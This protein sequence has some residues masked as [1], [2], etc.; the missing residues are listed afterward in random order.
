MKEE[1]DNEEK[2]SG[3]DEEQ[4]I[5]LLELALK[6]WDARKKILL[7]GLYGAILGIIIA[8]STPKEYTATTR[9]V[10]ETGAARSNNL[11]AIA[12]LAGIGG[13]STGGADAVYPSLYP[14][15]VASKPFTF[16]L[17]D[18]M[19]PV[20]KS[21]VDSLTLYEIIAQ[22]TSKPWWNVITGLP[23]RIVGTVTGA[24]EPK[25][26][27]R[28]INQG[29]SESSDS[30]NM[31]A[32][33]VDVF[34]LT[35]SQLGVMGQINQRVSANLD[36]RNNVVTISVTLQDPLAAATLADTV[37]ARLK[38]YVVAYRTDK[39]RNDLEYAKKLKEEAKETYYEAQQKYANY[40]D[41]NQGLV[42]RSA[43]I[44]QERLQNE[45]QLAFN[46]FNSTSQQVQISEA[47]V[48]SNTPVF[49][50]LE[51]V[52]VPTS[53][54]KPRTMFLVMAFLFLGIMAACAYILFWPPLSNIVKEKNKE[55]KQIKDQKA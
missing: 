9:L 39:A 19:L 28:I 30:L 49:T 20:E 29:N 1:K 54:S 44:E 12:A 16:E 48:Q 18:I 33:K 11:G 7:W 17:L 24:F 13:T 8:L 47:K 22:E 41:R 6:L 2:L 43:A 5:D 51:P 21:G 40:A 53:A 25:K 4:E 10:P 37:S 42:S 52:S 35:P 32:K 15:V 46:L 3:L 23:G 31:G 55:R 38:E 26:P 27:A 36:S 14:D 50:V 34:Q 45:A